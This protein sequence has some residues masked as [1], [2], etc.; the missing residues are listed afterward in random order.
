LLRV[1]A[2]LKLSSQEESI[3]VVAENPREEERSK[4]ARVRRERM[5]EGGVGFYGV[6]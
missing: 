6:G 3:P 5:S 4:D 2:K 1:V